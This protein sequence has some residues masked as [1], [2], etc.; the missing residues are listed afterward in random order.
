[1]LDLRV[2]F[3][4]AHTTVTHFKSQIF[5]NRGLDLSTKVNFLRSLVFSAMHF[6]AAGWVLHSRREKD[7]LQKGHFKLL[8]R[9][10]MLHF[11][12]TALKWEAGRVYSELGVQTADEFLREARLRFCLQLVHHG[13]PHLWALLQLEQHW[14]ALLQGDFEWLR[15]IVPEI[16]LPPLTEASWDVISAYITESKG[17]WKAVIRKAVHRHISDSKRSYQWDRWHKDI[18]REFLEQGVNF[19][20][21]KANDL[22][23]L[24]AKCKLRFATQAAQTVHAFK[25]HNRICEVR[26]FVSGTQCEAC[27]RQYSSHVNLINHAKRK[28]ACRLFYLSRGH[29]VEIQAGVN[30]RG[31][32]GKLTEWSNPYLQAQGPRNCEECST[33]SLIHPQQTDFDDLS[34]SW[35]RGVQEAIDVRTD[36]LEGLRVATGRTVLLP[37]EVIEHF[38]QWLNDWNSNMEDISLE[39]L[40]RISSFRYHF[41]AEWIID[42][43]FEVAAQSGCAVD[44][45]HREADSLMPLHGPARQLPTFDVHV[46]AHLFS[47]H[48]RPEDLQ[49][50]LEAKGFKTISIDIIF[51][52]VKGNLLRRDTFLFF[53]Q[54]LYAGWLNHHARHGPRF[55]QMRL[56]GGVTQEWFGL[57]NALSDERT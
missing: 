28:E 14:V 21:Q 46:V 25:K 37:K 20:D 2:R 23:F 41:C 54:A 31:A 29:R 11:G 49:S 53:K 8:K 51:D 27:L 22:G 5:G 15:E 30:N 52:Q 18:Y 19:A 36:V 42:G 50:V 43:E 6:N 4:C 10:A 48:R 24:C 34:A 47:G 39:T 17:R 13:T 9:V 55:E 1:M 33:V 12:Q 35:T 45:F 44:L 7:C 16:E 3:G 57:P 40:Q 38:E 26:H 32:A 56:K